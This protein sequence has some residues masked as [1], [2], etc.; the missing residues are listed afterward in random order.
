MKEKLAE[1]APT[2]LK[3]LIILWALFVIGLALWIDN[4]WLLA[5]ILAWEVLP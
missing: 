4:P 3:T 5:G 2:T 1:W